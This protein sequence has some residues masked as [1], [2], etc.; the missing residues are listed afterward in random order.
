MRTLN[1]ILEGFFDNVGVEKDT[2]KAIIIQNAEKYFDDM[3]EKLMKF[4]K[5]STY[6][7]AR[8][9]YNALDAKDRE[10]YIELFGTIISDGGFC[11]MVLSTEDKDVKHTYRDA[12]AYTLRTFE[13]TSNL[14]KIAIYPLYVH[15][16]PSRAF[17][18]F[19]R[20]IYT[21]AND[22]D[23]YYTGLTN[24]TYNV[25]DIFICKK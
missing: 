6:S 9:S 12:D 10:E 23:T 14:K 24:G 22:F 13:P 3:V 20:V 8:V 11:V 7:S 18:E 17:L 4:A 5:K 21:K 16:D 25:G 19:Y 1:D 2:K 15:L